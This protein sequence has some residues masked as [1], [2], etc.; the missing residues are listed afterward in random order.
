MPH[1]CKMGNL[2]GRGRNK[3]QTVKST[4]LMVKNIRIQI[5]YKS[6]TDHPRYAVG[7]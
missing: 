4:G 5:K 1:N 6:V 3:E 7:L 2:K